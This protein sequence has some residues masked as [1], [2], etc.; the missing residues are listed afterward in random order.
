MRNCQTIYK[1]TYTILYASLK[2]KRGD[3]MTKHARRRACASTPGDERE[4]H[5][6][7]CTFQRA[8]C[9]EGKPDLYVEGARSTAKSGPPLHLQLE[10]SPAVG[11]AGS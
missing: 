8:G 3:K 4:A 11:T 10:E 6:Y 5:E 7:Q 2:I 1:N 9:R